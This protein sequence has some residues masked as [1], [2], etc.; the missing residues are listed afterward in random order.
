[1]ISSISGNSVDIYKTAPVSKSSFKS[2]KISTE[3][4]SQSYSLNVW[5][6]VDSFLDLCSTKGLSLSGLSGKEKIQFYQIIAKLLKKGI[7]GY[8]YFE[9]N[10]RIEKHF[11][12]N[13]IAN[14]RLANAK[15]VR[16]YYA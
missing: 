7:I 1:M 11:I 9:I 8:N 3:S 5:N 14:R 4:M 16:N 13:Q 15:I 2:E 12:E 6:K 10:G